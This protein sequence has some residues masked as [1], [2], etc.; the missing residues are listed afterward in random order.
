MRAHGSCRQCVLSLLWNRWH[1]CFVQLGRQHACH[2]CVAGGIGQAYRLSCNLPCG[3]LLVP[4]LLIYLGNKT[5]L[6]DVTVSD[7]LAEINVKAFSRRPGQ[8][9]R[10][11][12]KKV[13]K[14]YEWV[15]DAM[16]AIQ[17]PFSV[18]TQGGLSKSA[19]QLIQEIHHRTRL[20]DA[21]LLSVRPREVGA[22][23][24]GQRWGGGQWL[25]GVVLHAA[26][27]CY[28]MRKVR[29][30]MALSPLDQ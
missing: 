24:R 22:G 5:Y 8:L 10:D 17:L 4:D 14:K 13:N 7:T 25:R 26:S 23:S 29:L 1:C 30:S 19:Q 6:C 18:E 2:P 21:G 16:G 3:G 20:L 9:A 12:A 27:S 15:A 11:A 28:C